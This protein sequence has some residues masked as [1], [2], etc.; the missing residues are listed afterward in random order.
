MCHVIRFDDKTVNVRHVTWNIID[1]PWF[2]QITCHFSQVCVETPIKGSIIDY[3]PFI[4]LLFCLIL[5]DLWILIGLCMLPSYCKMFSF[6]NL[7]SAFNGL[8]YLNVC[9]V[10]PGLKWHRICDLTRNSCSNY[11]DKKRL[12][13]RFIFLFHCIVVSA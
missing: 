3:P 12:N 6:L 2:C 11:I 8:C 10:N 5:W 1:C 9:N 7:V 4:R 13:L